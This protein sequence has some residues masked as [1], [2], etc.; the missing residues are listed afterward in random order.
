[1][2]SKINSAGQDSGHPEADADAAFHG[3]CGQSNLWKDVDPRGP[4]SGKKVDS[5]GKDE[6]GEGTGFSGII[7]GLVAEYKKIFGKSTDSPAGAPG[8]RGAAEPRNPGGEGARVETPAG[9]RSEIPNLAPGVKDDSAKGGKIVD[10][11]SQRREREARASGDVKKGV[12][13][14]EAGEEHKEQSGEF[15]AFKSAAA[16]AAEYSLL[17][18]AR[19]IANIARGLSAPQEGESSKPDADKPAESNGSK[20][21]ADKSTGS[22]GKGEDGSTPKESKDTPTNSEKPKYDN[23]SMT[24][25]GKVERLDTGNRS[26]RL[27]GNDNGK[28]QYLVTTPDD[29]EGQVLN[30]NV[31]V[32]NGK[33]TVSDNDAGSTQVYSHAE[34]EKASPNSSSSSISDNSFYGYAHDMTVAATKAVLGSAAAEAVDSV[35][36]DPSKIQEWYNEAAASAQK[37]AEQAQA[38]AAH[39][40]SDSPAE[41][42]PSPPGDTNAGEAKPQSGSVNPAEAKPDAGY[43]DESGNREPAVN[44]SSNRDSNVQIAD[45]NSATPR[46]SADINDGGARPAINSDRVIDTTGGVTSGNGNIPRVGDPGAPGAP[47]VVPSDATPNGGQFS[48][49]LPYANLAGGDSGGGLQLRPNTV[50]ADAGGAGLLRPNTVGADGGF[51]P[52]S[53]PDFARMPAPLVTSIEPSHIVRQ[54]DLPVSITSGDGRLHTTENLAPLPSYINNAHPGLPPAAAPEPLMARSPALPPNISTLDRSSLPVNQAKPLDMD[55]VG[56]ETVSKLVAQPVPSTG[57]DQPTVT[58]ST[59]KALD[60]PTVQAKPEPTSL[61][62]VEPAT[63]PSRFDPTVQ[64][65]KLDPSRIPDQ[66]TEKS[67]PVTDTGSRPPVSVNPLNPVNPL[68]PAPGPTLNPSLSPILNPSTNPSLNPALNPA[69]NPAANPALGPSLRVQTDVISIVQPGRTDPQVVGTRVA[70]DALQGRVDSS[71]RVIRPGDLGADPVALASGRGKTGPEGRYMIAELTLAMVLAAGG[72]RRILPTDAASKADAG[73]GSASN[74]RR[75]IERELSGKMQDNLGANGLKFMPASFK[76]AQLGLQKDIR[77]ALQA[78]NLAS[79]RQLF[80]GPNGSAAFVKSFG[81]QGREVP[82]VLRQNQPVQIALGFTPNQ[83]VPVLAEAAGGRQFALPAEPSVFDQ[84]LRAQQAALDG[85]I[86]PLINAAHDFIEIDDPFQSFK[87]VFTSRG[88]ARRLRLSGVKDGGGDL[89][90]QSVSGGDADGN[91]Q[92]EDEDPNQ[93]KNVVLLRPTSLIGAGQTLVS[94]AEEQFSDPY[95]GWLIADLNE[96]NC[97]EHWMDGKRIVEFQSRQQ[98]T[99]PVWQDIVE[100]YGSMPEE[101]RPENLVTIVTATEIDREV[102]NNVLGPIVGRKSGSKSIDEPSIKTESGLSTAEPAK[103]AV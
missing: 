14:S 48:P 54:A 71:V 60:L 10:D 40:H 37:A 70:P 43:R 78:A 50:G 46:T 7:S 81:L 28:D 87:D 1:M 41:S 80:L 25:E 76:I 67:A 77:N 75:Q 31:T 39:E 73:G 5:A 2:D 95:I 18:P 72:I 20:P 85:A 65:P 38:Q 45:S 101:A 11:E 84:F 56:P 103:E 3:G 102:I 92:G 82:G 91:D 55:K 88:S 97:Q 86:G 89:E 30:G 6:H 52:G 34:V 24:P 17:N 29:Q 12:Q 83:L 90:R 94:I 66:V 68:S 16:L 47:L 100:F 33:V 15:D 99:L 32:H 51:V 61:Q 62:R 22:N 13:S 69:A 49:S 27:I 57:K 35:F 64:A 8:E 63:Q 79:G 4:L 21:D 74:G 42:K 93:P 98:L 53:T 26:Y 96:G 58:I 23:L 36:K 44:P 59:G 9:N 19:V